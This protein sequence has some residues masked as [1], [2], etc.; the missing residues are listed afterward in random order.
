MSVGARTGRVIHKMSHY[1]QGL[2]DMGG[3]LQC[4]CMPLDAA[5]QYESSMIK[6]RGCETLLA[7]AE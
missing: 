7:L 6:G 4:N 2:S 1:V 3:E 5:G